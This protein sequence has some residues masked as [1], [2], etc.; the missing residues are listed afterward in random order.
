M[1]LLGPAL[2]YTLASACL[3]I[4]IAPNL[5]PVIDNRDPRWIGAWFIGWLLFAVV[6]LVFA[7]AVSM[8]PKE[9]PRAALRRRI[10]EEKI[11][12]GLKVASERN[13]VGVSEASLSDMVVTFKRLFKNK[14]FMLMQ[15]A[16][17]LHIFGFLPYWIYTPKMVSNFK[18]LVKKFKTF[19]KFL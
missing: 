2:G 9:L 10:E 19:S 3:K 4:Y 18:I 13:S 1:R 7:F 15:L 14:T 5:T 12:R 16:G 17:I 6:L 11:K 8:F